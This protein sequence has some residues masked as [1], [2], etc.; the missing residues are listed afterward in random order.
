MVGGVKN[1]PRALRSAGVSRELDS[2]TVTFVIV[3][4][5]ADTASEP[6]RVPAGSLRLSLQGG[7]LIEP[8]GERP[9]GPLAHVNV[10]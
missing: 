5:R 2:A 9:E 7:K 8:V 1:A 10:S 6:R 3:Y 4:E